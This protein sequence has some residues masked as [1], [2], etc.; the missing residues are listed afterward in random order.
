MACWSSTTICAR[1]AG[2]REL[3][4]PLIP[5]AA[6]EKIDVSLLVI[7]DRIRA[8]WILAGRDSRPG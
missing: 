5:N 4:V 6:D 2:A 1:I 3:R 7:D 8:V